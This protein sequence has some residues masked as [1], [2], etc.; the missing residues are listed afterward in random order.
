MPEATV[1]TVNPS[2]TV[3]R[4]ACPRD[5][6]E[7]CAFEDIDET[8]SIISST[9][10]EAVLS[11]TSPAEPVFYQSWGLDYI[12][13]AATQTLTI[14]INGDVNDNTNGTITA[15]LSSD[16]FVYKTAAI[17]EGASL[18]SGDMG[19]TSV[20]RTTDGASASMPRSTDSASTSPT[21][22]AVP[23]ATGSAPASASTGAAAGIVAGKSALLALAGAAILNVW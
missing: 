3:L 5:H 21:S 9:R 12:A 11:R 1:L 16:F 2:T 15:P 22:G 6:T 19:T 20:P 17:V 13:G 8:Y 7:Y 4:L 18:L 23:S 10:Y 14:V